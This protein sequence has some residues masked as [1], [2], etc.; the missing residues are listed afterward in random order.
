MKVGDTIQTVYGPGQLVLYREVDHVY[1]IDLPFGKLYANKK[2]LLND[3]AAA[4]TTGNTQGKKKSAMEINEAY[5]S[6]E[7]MRR[8][9]L[10][11]TCQE[12]GIPMVDFDQCVTCLMTKDTEKEDTSN[13]PRFH[14]IRRLVEETK[15]LKPKKPCPPCLTC[16]APVCSN[17]TSGTFRAEK[18]NV[19]LE[20]E[21]L[22]NFEY[23]VGCLTMDK[24]QRQER[25]NHMIDLYDRT[26]LLLK[27][28]SQYIDSVADSLE[29][30]MVKQNR[31]SLGGSSA[32][33]VSGALGIAAAAT[34]LTPV[35]PPLLVASL[36]FGGRYVLMFVYRRSSRI[37]FSPLTN[38]PTLSTRCNQR[39]CG[40]NGNRG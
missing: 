9:N 15:K 40:T 6:L 11:V 31:V 22:F 26:L 23:I 36:L 19:C 18:V 33:I 4:T 17:H 39:N 21:K 8:L 7:K 3:E 27:Y 13:P 20:C 32:G 37:L 38:F 1:K 28:S 14:R 10:E 29:Q 5:E 12:H 2:A 24:R 25:V 16:G 30:T 34:I 35:G